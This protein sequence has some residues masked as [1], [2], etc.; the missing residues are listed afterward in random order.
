M[1]ARGRRPRRRSSTRSRAATSRE[2]CALRRRCVTFAHSLTL[3]SLLFLTMR[4][5]VCCAVLWRCAS[6]GPPSPTPTYSI[7]SPL[8]SPPPARAKLAA[9]EAELEDRTQRLLQ[10]SRTGIAAAKINKRF[11][12]INALKAPKEAADEMR[13]NTA[14]GGPADTVSRAACDRRAA[15]A[16]LRPTLSHPFSNALAFFRAQGG[17]VNPYARVETIATIMWDTSGSVEKKEEKLSDAVLEQ[18]ANVFALDEAS[19][20]LGIVP[21][22][23]APPPPAAAT[24]A[25]AAP[26]KR[27]QGAISLSQWKARRS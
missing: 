3:G 7:A 18:R 14:R 19:R 1:R 4:S 16:V 5:L 27:R 12:S 22:A 13:E 21:L 25:A 26:V 8:P 2:R 24:A 23:P 6:C 20:A 9:L 17:V 11:E 15:D 10:G